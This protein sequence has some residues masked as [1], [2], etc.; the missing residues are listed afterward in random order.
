M[1]MKEQE[2]VGRKKEAFIHLQWEAAL[3]GQFGGND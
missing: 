1:L 2:E 3:I